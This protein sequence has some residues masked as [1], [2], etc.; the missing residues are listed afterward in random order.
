MHDTQK[1]SPRGAR[2]KEN[3]RASSHTLKGMGLNGGWMA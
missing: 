2:K 1:P 3:G